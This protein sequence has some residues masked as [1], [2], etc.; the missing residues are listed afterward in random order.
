MTHQP[1]EGPSRPSWGLAAVGAFL[2]YGAFTTPLHPGGA[3]FAVVAG[4]VCIA[5]AFR[6]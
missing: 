3:T 5:A 1:T 4:I 6:P 2:I